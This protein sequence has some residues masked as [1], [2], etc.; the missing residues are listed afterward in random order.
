MILKTTAIH[1]N[2]NELAQLATSK[3]L[4]PEFVFIPLTNF[5]CA[6]ATISIKENDKVYLGQQIGMRKGPFFDQPFFSTVSGT[7]LGLEKHGY[8]NGKVVDYLKIKNDHKDTKD[9]S[10]KDRSDEEIAKLDQAALVEIAKDKALVGLGGSSFP[11]Y[12]KLNTKNQIKTILINGI[13]CEPMLTSD[14]RF[15]KENAPAIIEGIK[16]MMSALKCNDARIAIKI[17]HPDVIAYYEGLLE[18]EKGIKVAVVKDFYPQGWEIA[19]IKSVLDIDV[20]NGHLP[21]EYGV[22]DF[23]VA[24]AASLYEAVKH[25]MPVIDRY[26]SVYGDGIVK[27]SNYIVRVGTPLKTLVEKSGG[28]TSEGE[29]KVLVLGGPMMGSSIPSDDCITSP[30]VTSLLVLNLKYEQMEPCIRCSSCVLSCPEGLKPVTIMNLM[31]MKH[32]SAK[33]VNKLEPMKC[34]ECGLC[35]YSCTS[36]I[37]LLYYIRQ[38]KALVRTLPKK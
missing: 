37:P 15:M 36:K 1:D 17:K 18:K 13:E 25:N 20:P 12:V 22:M 28:Y 26:V 6:A 7:Y 31:R 14:Q 29:N 8:R 38:A 30:T 32:P 9:P 5:R 35:T 16:I 23:N 4:D 10:I 27:P 24:T 3:L 2:K 33:L 21:S 34:M 19:M 11:S